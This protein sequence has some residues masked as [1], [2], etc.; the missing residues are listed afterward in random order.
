MKKDFVVY[1]A[2]F[3]PENEC[4]NVTF[5][6]IPEAITFGE[7][8]EQS[9]QMAQEALGIVIYDQS[10]LPEPSAQKDIKVAGD[11]FVVMIA[12]DLADYRR[13]FCS[14]TIRKNTSIPEWLNDLAEREHLNFSQILTKALKRELGIK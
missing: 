14:K 8:F 3:S 12:L 7:G 2:I 4:F 11:D 9:V 6:D 5:P 1:P 13:K 10:D